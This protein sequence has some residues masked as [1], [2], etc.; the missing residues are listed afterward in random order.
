MHRASAVPETT[1]ILKT[2]LKTKKKK[3]YKKQNHVNYSVVHSLSVIE[4]GQ[5]SDAGVI[6]PNVK[7][8]NYLLK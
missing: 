5:L 2:R 6:L 1:S 3:S 4:K 7:G 8:F